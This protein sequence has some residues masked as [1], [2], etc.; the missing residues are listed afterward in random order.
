MKFTKNQKVLGTI[1]AFLILVL[2]FS[3]ALSIANFTTLSVSKTTENGKDIIL[4]TGLSGVGADELTGT[5][6]KAQFPDWNTNVPLTIKVTRQNPFVTYLLRDA[7]AGSDIFTYQLASSCD[8]YYPFGSCPLL[9]DTFA[10]SCTQGDNTAML[11]DSGEIANPHWRCYKKSNTWKISTAGQSGAVFDPAAKITLTMSGYS[12]KDTLL[13]KNDLSGNLETTSGVVVGTVYAGTFVNGLQNIPPESG[14]YSIRT[15][16]AGNSISE[17]NIV[18]GP[19]LTTLYTNAVNELSTCLKSHSTNPSSI[20]FGSPTGFFGIGFPVTTSGNFDSG[21]TTCFEQYQSRIVGLPST[22]KH[23]EIYNTNPSIVSVDTESRKLLIQDNYKI[24]IINLRIYA[25]K[26]GITRSIAIPGTI[27]CDKDLTNLPQF[28]DGVMKTNIKNTGA[29]GVIFYS[30]SCTGSVTPL[31]GS[32]QV[33]IN[34]GATESVYINIHSDG[35]GGT[36]SC[37]ITA[38]STD[39]STTKSVSCGYKSNKICDN[40]PL[41]GFVLNE[42]CEN[43]C[44][45]TQAMCG[46]KKLYAPST[47]YPN[48]CYCGTVDPYN[49][50]SGQHWDGTKCIIDGGTD[51]STTCMPFV[52]K[53]VT[54]FPNPIFGLFGF[55]G[56]LSCVWD[57]TN[58][59]IIIVAF[60]L[61][62][63]FYGE[64]RDKPDTKKLGTAA[65]I[66]GVAL[67]AGN[68]FFESTIL[69]VFGG[70]GILLVILGI[71]ALY[72]AVKGII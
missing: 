8:G 42:N 68:I 38:K 15:P 47:G 34:S 67:I 63:F 49:C 32:G 39:L 21:Y 62:V 35:S 59:G 5:L 20:V 58:I 57:M 14:I 43:V 3:Q 10:S 30:V 7:P 69:S 44:T 51:N 46:D 16:N 31:L 37:T 72:V 26:V 64:S 45:V 4:V 17:M 19:T 61:I 25:E 36:G 1:S 71:V 65:L 48:Q 18:Y 56:S 60:G 70:N 66:L 28:Y 13:T 50:P 40:A 9:K 53:S 24:P 11:I 29:D 54:S 2:I 27:T 6:S 33:N 22:A 23:N 12:F 55:G 52:Q 41:S